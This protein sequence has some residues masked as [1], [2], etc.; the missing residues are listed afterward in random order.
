MHSFKHSI[1]L[2]H[3]LGI[4]CALV[5]LEESPEGG[6]LFRAAFDRRQNH[7]VVIHVVNIRFQFT[8]ELDE[9]VSEALIG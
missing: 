2:R 3:H 1:N 4:S 9:Y 7:R 5:S 8:S 6:V